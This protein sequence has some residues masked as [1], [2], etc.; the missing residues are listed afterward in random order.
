MTTTFPIRTHDQRA[1]LGVAFS[2]S[3][4]AALAVTLRLIAHAIAHKRWTIADYFIIA[5]CVRDLA[6]DIANTTEI[7]QIFAIGL[8]SISITGV[9]HA[10]IGYDHVQNIVVAY[11]P[12]PITKLSQ[13]IIPL[14]FLWVLSLSCTKISILSLYI[15]I[16]PIRW[17]VW[18]SYVTMSIIVAWTIATILAGCLICRPFAYNWDKSI[19]GGSCGDKVTSF[20]ITGVIN[21]VTDVMVLLLPMRPLYQ[22][23]MATYKRVTLVAVFGLGTL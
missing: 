8:Q 16:F 1:V 18:S 2:F 22:L 15:L 19:P 7:L 4:L 3:I 10:G 14:Q 12:E 9:F 23:Q 6:P 21:L 13:L 20:T 17:V 5:A 11:G